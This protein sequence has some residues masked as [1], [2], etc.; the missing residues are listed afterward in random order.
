MLAIVVTAG[1]FAIAACSPSSPGD[2]KTPVSGGTLNIGVTADIV[3]TIP[4][5]SA[6]QNTTAILANMYDTLV[7][8]PKSGTEPEPALATEWTVSDDGLTYDFTVRDG[9]DFHDGTPLTAKDIVWSIEYAMKD[10]NQASSLANIAGLTADDDTHVTMKMSK[11]QPDILVALEDPNM[12]IIPADFGGRS[13]DEFRAAPIGSGPFSFTGRTVGTDIEF[14]R[15][16]KYWGDVPLVDTLHFKVFPDVNAL[17]V[18]L[19]SGDIDIVSNV[20]LDSVALMDG[21]VV[22]SAPQLVEML[23]INSNTPALQDAKLRRAL[24]MSIDRDQIVKSLLSGYGEPATTL[25]SVSSFPKGAPNIQ[26]SPYIFDEAK[27][28][29][30]VA[31][32]GYTGTPLRLIYST[33]IPSDVSL[34][35][36]LQAEWKKAGI[37][38]ELKPLES[39]EWLKAVTATPPH[40]NFDLSISR[41]GGASPT[42]QL[43]FVIDSQ[44]FGGGWDVSTVKQTLGDYSDARDPA[45]QQKVLANYEQNLSQTLE[46]VTIA[47][48]GIVSVISDKVQGFEP[49]VSEFFPLN[50]VSLT[51]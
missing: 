15:F 45:T 26:D 10:P 16:G 13:I 42:P 12:S 30:L 22:T 34:A 33:G 50:T 2:E 31:E 32:S 20:S 9:V 29:A 18:A 51:S 21:K 11:P 5:A 6:Q 44:Y 46:A 4:S 28:A 47:Y 43:G 49:R 41:A 23:Q 14:A 48:F 38:I 17:S 37:T 8:A 40:D 7:A 36:A 19:Q 24:S 25:L 39:G 3:E 1:M 27:A 35:A